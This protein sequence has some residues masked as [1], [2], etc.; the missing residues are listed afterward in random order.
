MEN[1]SVKIYLRVRPAQIWEAVSPAKTY[2]DLKSS[3]KQM[4]V[5]ENTPHAFDNVFYHSSTQEEV[6]ERIVSIKNS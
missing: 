1:S 3:S 4:I 2:I 5:I 6:F